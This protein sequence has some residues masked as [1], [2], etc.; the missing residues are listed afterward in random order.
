LDVKLRSGAEV[1]IGSVANI[2]QLARPERL[3]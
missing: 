1:T 2:E 3:R